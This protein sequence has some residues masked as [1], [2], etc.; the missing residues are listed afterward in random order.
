MAGAG[1]GEKFGKALD[2]AE[3]G[4][5]KQ[6]YGF[7]EVAD[8]RERRE[9]YPPHGIDCSYCASALCRLFRRHG[10]LFQPIQPDH[11]L[12]ARLAAHLR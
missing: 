8:M 6:Q 12:L 5:F 11:R 10:F 2:D 4:G 3:N 7:H 9:L 1:D